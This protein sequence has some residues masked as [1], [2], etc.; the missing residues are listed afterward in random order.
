[1]KKAGSAGK[2]LER[3]IVVL[4]QKT[5][6]RI[7]ASKFF[8]FVLFVLIC[9]CRWKEEDKFL[10]YE[11]ILDQEENDSFSA[12]ILVGDRESAIVGFFHQK[13][14]AVDL[15]QDYYRFPLPEGA[16]SYQIRL[17]A[18]PGVDSVVTVYNGKRD[19][20]FVMDERGVGEAEIIWNYYC[21]YSEIYISVQSKY[22]YNENVPYVMTVKADTKEK[23]MEIE[24]NNT[25]D[26]A[27]ILIP[28]VPLK[29]YIVPAYDID[30]YQLEFGDG[31]SD[32]QAK[33]ESLSSLDINMMLIDKNSGKSVF[34]NEA[35]FGGTEVTQYFA[36]NKGKYYVR[37]TG[38]IGDLQKEPLYYITLEILPGKTSYEREFNDIRES[39]SVLIP[40]EEMVGIL[41]KND[42]DYFQFDVLRPKAKVD[43][44]LESL[45]GRDFSM[46][47]LDA[48]EKMVYSAVGTEN[49]SLRDIK[50]GR[51]YVCL[52]KK[53]DSGE[54][55]A[56]QLFLNIYD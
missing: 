14:N 36:S 6:I 16:A 32:F 47:I 1:M 24:P 3:E 15:D 21:K 49:I 5:L 27:T 51:Y 9:S 43:F 39:A 23:T 2:I 31:V 25:E 10:P 34:I 22:G 4:F 30:Y 46:E 55:S 54:R 12:A 28:G 7:W 44:S 8:F 53:S 37:I 50:K 38:I 18:V 29:G 19:K 41:E 11:T 35:G 42:V 48:E 17:T 52:K 20:L 56:Y 33:V 40:Q 45:N 13:T 26:A